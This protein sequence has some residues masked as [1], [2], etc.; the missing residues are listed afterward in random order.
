MSP[1]CDIYS[2]GCLM[3]EMLH[4]QPLWVGLSQDAILARVAE[5]QEGPPFARHIPAPVQVRAGLL[6]ACLGPRPFARSANA[7]RASMH[8]N[9]HLRSCSR[10]QVDACR[11][12]PPR[13]PIPPLVA[14]QSPLLPSGYPQHIPSDLTSQGRGPCTHGREE[15]AQWTHAAAALRRTAP[16]PPPP[17]PAPVGAGT[18]LRCGRSAWWRAAWRALAPAGHRRPC[19]TSACRPCCARWG[20]TSRLPPQRPCPVS[21]TLGCAVRLVCSVLPLP[22]A[23]AVPGGAALHWALLCWHEWRL[24][25]PYV[26]GGGGW[27]GCT[28]GRL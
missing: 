26:W 28:G 1:A 10:A 27:G 3:W 17:R 11:P 14:A 18:E 9:L 20:P 15:S 12:T 19:C 25:R 8:H 5:V 13:P 23:Q 6:F 16:Q 24:L 7:G 21:A 2:L 22:A 4:A